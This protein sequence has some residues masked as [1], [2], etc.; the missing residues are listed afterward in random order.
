MGRF[1]D[2]LR[3]IED[4]LDITLF[5]RWL[6]IIIGAMCAIVILPFAIMSIIL[7]SPPWLSATITVLIIIGWGV[8]GG[9]KEW[10]LHKRSKEKAKFVGQ[11]TLPF[12]YEGRSKKENEY[13]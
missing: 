4:I 1:S 13:D 5:N 2:W 11:D 9:Y 10:L 12:N 3:E 7:M 8:A 6:W